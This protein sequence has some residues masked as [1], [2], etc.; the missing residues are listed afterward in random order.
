VSWRRFLR[1]HA[2]RVIAQT[3][4]LGGRHLIG[5][6]TDPKYFTLWEDRGLHITPVHY[7]QPIPDTRTLPSDLWERTS[8]LEGV[9]LDVQS[10][11]ALLEEFRRNFEPEYSRFPM[12]PIAPQTFHLKN[13]SFAAV[14]AEILYCMIRHFKPSIVFEVGS[15]NSTLMAA[16]AV[17]QNSIEG[18][19][20]ELI[21]CDPHPSR[22]LLLHGLPGLSRIVESRI[23]NVPLTEFS[24]LKANDILF[25]DSSHN[26]RIGGDVQYEYLEI[27]PRLRKG[28]FVH[29]HDI[30]LPE[31]YPFDY[32]MN[33]RLF[34]TEQYLLQ[35]FLSFNDSFRVVWSARYLHIHHPHALRAAFESYDSVTS[36]PVSFWMQKIA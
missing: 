18:H 10:Q 24:R 20:C 17:V 6:L 23:E 16:Q 4:S 8:S 14:D 9:D 22:E 27:L 21:S 36:W 11:L 5:L 33:R 28:V 32:V 12:D 26:L 13:W 19:A 25:I 31:E 30:F 2:A 1:D 3:I 29:A 15:G 35:A 34:W 7:Y